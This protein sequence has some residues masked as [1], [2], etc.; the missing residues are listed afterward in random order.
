MKDRDFLCWL[1]ERLEHVHNE[2]KLCDYMH[3]LRAII[4]AIPPDQETPNLARYNS[5]EELQAVEYPPLTKAPSES[6]Q[7]ECVGCQGQG[8]DCADDCI[9]P[10]SAPEHIPDI[11]KMVQLLVR[12]KNA[13]A[14]QGHMPF[15]EQGHELNCPLCSAAELIDQ[16]ILY[17][18]NGKEAL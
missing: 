1:H 3:K 17:A 18:T 15:G 5:L 16:V 11:G 4:G 12:A 7:S 10:Q 9:K 13:L 14:G 2:N 8:I 6:P